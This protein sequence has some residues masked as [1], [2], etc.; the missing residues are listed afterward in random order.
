MNDSD[1]IEGIADFFIKDRTDE[2]EKLKPDGIVVISISESKILSEMLEEKR[3]KFRKILRE[4]II[5]AYIKHNL[6]DTNITKIDEIT[7]EYKKIDLKIHIPQSISIT[8]INAEEH[9]RRIITFPCEVQ[10]ISELKTIPLTEI[11]VCNDC[12]EDVS[13]NYNPDR[14]GSP[15]CAMC[16]GKTKSDGIGESE[17]VVTVYLKEIAKD[18]NKRNPIRFMADIHREQART[19]DYNQKV[20]VTGIFKSIPPNTARNKSKIKSEILIDV[21]TFESMEIDRSGK[22]D[23]LS[24]EKFKQLAKDGKL[25]EMLVNSYAPHI[26]YGDEAKLA[27]ILNVLGGVRQDD[28]KDRI[29]IGFF[30]DPATSKTEIGNWMVKITPNSTII[31][32]TASTGVGLGAG[33]IKLPDGTQSMSLGPLVKNDYVVINEL[34]KM[35]RENYNMLLETFENG[36]CSRDI[37]GMNI[38]FNTNVSIITTANPIGGKWDLKHPSIAENINVEVQMLS[39]LDLMIRFLNIPNKVRDRAITDHIRKWRAGKIIPPFNEDELMRYLNTVRDSVPSMSEEK[40]KYLSDFYVERENYQQDEN[41]IS[42]DQRQYGAL[43]R[44]AYAFAKILFKPEVDEECINLTIDLYKKC[45]ESFGLS[46]EKGGS[47]SEASNNLIRYTETKDK[48]FLRIFRE[49]EKEKGE[50]FKEDLITKM[51]LEIHWKTKDDAINYIIKQHDRNT[52]IEKAN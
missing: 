41:S 40:E 14:R 50:V 38:A 51:L 9:E 36:R 23:P 20:M 19:V 49:L 1:Y 25:I 27:C 29:H 39:R 46:F 17:T 37:A 32:G 2:I 47:F 26:K 42:M 7:N 21:I 4:S 34:D 11:F 30:G 45:I 33:A 12:G 6:K 28:Y 24:L 35:K 43:V 44:M 15:E 52:I 8:E 16:K 10:T 5:R 22:L 3:E 13:Y 48:T 31:D 18:K